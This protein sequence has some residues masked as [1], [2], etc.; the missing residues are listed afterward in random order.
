MEIIQN[1]INYADIDTL[2]LLILTSKEINNTLNKLE[3]LQL[4]V[5]ILNN[6]YYKKYNIK[7][8]NQLY[9]LY[10]HFNN[11]QHI[12]TYIANHFRDYDF[13][14]A[15]E[16]ESE[17]YIVIY[18]ETYEDF[19][20]RQQEFLL[21]STKD[22]INVLLFIMKGLDMIDKDDMTVI[23]TDGF[24]FDVLGDLYMLRPR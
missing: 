16:E 3:N 23:Y 1:M 6:S 4:L 19:L 8:F 17:A 5:Y 10:H 9:Q 20:Y 21:H 12:F 14:R 11:C 7:T 22:K 13:I 15:C 2:H 24:I 18:G